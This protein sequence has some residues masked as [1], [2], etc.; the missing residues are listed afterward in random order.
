V[1]SL[2][3]QV[4]VMT[5]AGSGGSIAVK[6]I[7]GTLNYIMIDPTGLAFNWQNSDYDIY[8]IPEKYWFKIL[9]PDGTAKA[10]NNKADFEADVSVSIKEGQYWKLSQI[11]KD[12]L[13]QNDITVEPEEN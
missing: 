1:K 5:H 12:I 3:Q 6:N 13:A 2:E 11:E 7:D 9:D 4:A 8:F 10:F